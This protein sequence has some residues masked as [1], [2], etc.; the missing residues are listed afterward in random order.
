MRKILS[1][2]IIA[3]LVTPSFAATRMPGLKS[4]ADNNGQ[5]D[6]SGDVN[7][8]NSWDTYAD[9]AVQKIYLARFV[10]SYIDM[11]E[12]DE[13]KVRDGLAEL[14]TRPDCQR[15]VL[16]GS[17]DSSGNVFI[18]EH[19]ANGRAEYIK[20]LLPSDFRNQKDMLVV[21]SGDVNSGIQEANVSREQLAELRA[22]GRAVYVIA[23]DK[24]QQCTIESV[25]KTCMDKAACREDTELKDWHKYLKDSCTNG[26]TTDAETFAKTKDKILNKFIQ[27]DGCCLDQKAAITQMLHFT[28]YNFNS[29]KAETDV[30]Y[31]W[32][33][34]SRA[35]DKDKLSVWKTENGRFNGARLG[36]DAGAGVV[37]GT[38]G[39]VIT[40]KV[41]KN[42]QKKNGLENIKC[43]IGGQEVAKFG[44]ETITE[45][46][47]NK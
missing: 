1:F 36:V 39:A 29:N 41:V 30:Q 28:I 11:N 34:I 14:F 16:I 27:S 8:G 31:A 37:L 13:K 21:N 44:E 10:T 15:V 38:V 23:I 32:S 12:D 47:L 9:D 33:V 17:A 2:L 24:C 3:L 40:N 45:I 18:N 19:L 20:S 35:I 46:R 42:S 7:D 25:I 22:M 5:Y 6:K 4:V 43:T 26:Y